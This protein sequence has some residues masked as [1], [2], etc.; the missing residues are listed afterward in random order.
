MQAARTIQKAFR[1][2]ASRD[3]NNTL[4]TTRAA[5]IIQRAYRRYQTRKS[6]VLVR[7]TVTLQALVRGYLFRL[8]WKRRAMRNAFLGQKRGN[9]NSKKGDLLRRI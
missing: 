4:R 3:P 5:I 1:S 7:A 2:F 9:W 6:E 8:K